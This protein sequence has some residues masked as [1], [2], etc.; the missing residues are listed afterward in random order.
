MDLFRC[1]Q[2]LSNLTQYPAYGLTTDLIKVFNALIQCR[3]V[4]QSSAAQSP[5][6]TLEQS[7]GVHVI[8][9]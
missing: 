7:P 1:H 5:S 3:S 8:H 2:T 9:L 6:F 4:N